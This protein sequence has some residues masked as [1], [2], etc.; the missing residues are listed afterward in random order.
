MFLFEPPGRD[1]FSTFAYHNIKK[2]YI[3]EFSKH[4]QKYNEPLYT[5][6]PVSTTIIILSLM[7]YHSLPL[8]LEYFKENSRRHI[9]PPSTQ[10]FEDKFQG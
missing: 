4:T 8:F 6:P 3:M 2:I 10:G 9:I 1:N 5:Q 7:F